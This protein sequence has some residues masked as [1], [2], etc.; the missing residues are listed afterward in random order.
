M[1]TE[2]RQVV[3]CATET[4]LRTLIVTEPPDDWRALVEQI[5]ELEEM[6]SEISGSRDH[7]AEAGRPGIERLLGEKRRELRLIDVG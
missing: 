3:V 7:Q 4:F 5:A 6:L 1:I 2:S